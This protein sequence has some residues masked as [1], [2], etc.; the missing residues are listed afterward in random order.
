MSKSTRLRGP[1]SQAFCFVLCGD[2]VLMLES[3]LLVGAYSKVVLHVIRIDEAR[4][5]FPLGPPCCRDTGL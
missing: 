2:T 5:R 4:V 3:F 1:T